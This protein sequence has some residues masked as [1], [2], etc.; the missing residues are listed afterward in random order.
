MTR[1]ALERA[2][3]SAPDP[4][5]RAHRA[6]PLPAS[7]EEARQRLG[8]RRRSADAAG[9]RLLRAVAAVAVVIVAV[10]GLAAGYRFVTRDGGSGE[11]EPLATGG[12]SAS[13]VA[14]PSASASA[15]PG[16]RACGAA[17]FAITS[18]S[19]DAGAGSRGTRV[20]FR[21]ADSLD[22]CL[23]G[24]RLAARI[25]DASGQLLVSAESAATTTTV[26]TPG[27]QLE[28]GVAWSN[29]CGAQPAE[30]VELLVRFPGDALEVP[31]VPPAGTS[32]LVPPCMGSG[33][34]TSL[35]ITGFEAS[36]RPPP[37]G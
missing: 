10:V 24:G 36:N 25:V 37:E 23:L 2:L 28:I 11:G 29:W 17:D 35:S 31:I 16:R 21:A 18:D 7:V 14:S 30:P 6:A 26:V 1:D 19:W 27:T 5:E 15:S 4:Y 12:A 34:D 13:I 8:S 22:G 3:R 33:Q 20:V 32:V 9:P